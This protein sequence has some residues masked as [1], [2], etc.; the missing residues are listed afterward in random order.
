MGHEAAPGT[1]HGGL[2]GIMPGTHAFIEVD[3]PPGEY[4]LLCVLP[5]RKDGKPHF[6]HGMQKQTNVT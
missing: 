1:I 5:D 6:M 4:G 3:L 2:S